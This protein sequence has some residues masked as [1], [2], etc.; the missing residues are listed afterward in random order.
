MQTL[1]ALLFFR[2]EEEVIRRIQQ[3]GPLFTNP[4]S[5][6]HGADMGPIWGRQDPMNIAIWEE[7]AVLLA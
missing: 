7:D 6:V 2:T 1:F 4:D 5:K 3:T